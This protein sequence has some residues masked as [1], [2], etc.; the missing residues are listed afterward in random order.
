[1]LTTVI[2]TSEFSFSGGQLKP[3]RYDY[4]KDGLGK[5]KQAFIAFDYRNKTLQHEDGT[6]E[7][8]EG[9]LDKLTY[10]YQLK[11]DLVRLESSESSSRTLDYTIADGDELKYYQFRIVGEEVLTTPAGDMLTVKLER[12]REHGNDRKTTF[13]LAKD[14]D[15]LLTKFKQQ[16]D[17]KGAELNLES[18]T[19]KE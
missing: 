9:T 7:L 14:H 18:F 19:L 11:L 17:G 2:E 6:S 8:I 13:W 16:E 10:Q 15:Y 1:M 3:H 12:V 4:A 5:S